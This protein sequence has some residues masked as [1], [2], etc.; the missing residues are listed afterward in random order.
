MGRVQ[1]L[2][3]A[4]FRRELWGGLLIALLCMR[5]QFSLAQ[6]DDQGP[7]SAPEPQGTSEPA[8]PVRAGENFVELLDRKSVVFPAIAFNA[9]RLSPKQKFQLAVNNSVALSRVVAIGITAGFNQA[10]DAPPRYE[11]GMS[12]YGKRFG[13]EL[14][15]STSTQMFGTFALAS[16]L[17][18]D[19]RFYFK[20]NLTMRESVVYAVD[21]V[22]FTRGDDGKQEFNWSGLLAPLAA[23]ALA[24]TYE[25]SGDNGT[26]DAFERYGYDL[27]W[28]A[29]GNLAKQYWPKINKHLRSHPTAQNG[30]P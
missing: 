13:S 14:A 20:D 24:N 19:P 25:P 18:Q 29:V 4:L 9:G 16:A 15:R 5:C 27:I 30:K 2:K 23:E 1:S 12:G 17:H 7:P 26:G 21:R 3:A 10:I 28:S 8:G 11:E 6:Q 22:F